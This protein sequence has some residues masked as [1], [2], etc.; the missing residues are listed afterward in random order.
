MRA[1]PRLAWAWPRPTGR[2]CGGAGLR[3]PS[4]RASFGRRSL[5]PPAAR[6]DVLRC[7]A[8][9]SPPRLHS[10]YCCRSLSSG[11][12]KHLLS[13]P[14][15]YVGW[16]VR[17]TPRGAPTRRAEPLQ[18]SPGVG[19]LRAPLPRLLRRT[20]GPGRRPWPQRTASCGACRT[21]AGARWCGASA[22]APSSSA[23]PQVSAGGAGRDGDVPGPVCRKRHGGW[24]VL[25]LKC[26]SR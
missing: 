23:S 11:A 20:R 22:A 10:A 7:R 9:A 26:V 19:K 16:A 15:A 6:R 8:A 13:L 24:K 5:R 3:K 25:F 4:M 12:S 21:S 1:W 18:V 17:G 2:G 14:A